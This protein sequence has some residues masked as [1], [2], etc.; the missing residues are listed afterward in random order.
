MAA[1]TSKKMEINPGILLNKEQVMERDQLYYVFTIEVQKM[2]VVEF[3]A[4][5]T[6]S[7]NIELEGKNNLI[8]VTNIEPYTSSVIARLI[9]KRDWKLKSKFK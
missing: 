3:V 6:G 8:S 1:P 9:L 4:D 5:F 2:K 7:E